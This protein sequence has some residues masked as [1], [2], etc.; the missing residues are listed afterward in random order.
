MCGRREEGG[1]Y[2]RHATLLPRASATRMVEHEH[3]NSPLLRQETA[4]T[5]MCFW[6][7]RRRPFVNKA[8]DGRIAHPTTR[9]LV[10]K[11]D[12]HRE[13]VKCPFE[14]CDQ[15]EVLCELMVIFILRSRSVC[16]LENN[17]VN[18]WFWVI[19]I[20]HSSNTRSRTT[21]RKFFFSTLGWS[22][23]Y[24]AHSEK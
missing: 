9:K 8:G 21:E 7:S 11:F 17:T 4:K 22:V 24:T 5:G 16:L 18:G 19:T 14:D 20:I 10:L 1:G 3:R 15:S 12:A 13:R 6:R 23:C 2:I